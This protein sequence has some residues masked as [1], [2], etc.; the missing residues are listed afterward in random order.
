MRARPETSR[1]RSPHRPAEEPG[2]IGRFTLYGVLQQPSECWQRTIGRK[3]A[4]DI[5]VASVESDHEKPGL[6]RII[7]VVGPKN[8]TN[9]APDGGPRAELEHRIRRANAVDLQGDWYLR[10][11]R[12]GILN[13]LFSPRHWEPTPRSTRYRTIRQ[14]ADGR[15]RIAFATRLPKV[16]Y[17]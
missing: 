9:Q 1:E 13:A 10:R 4:Y 15:S 5:L 3:G 7:L 11:T 6:H 16:E 2:R 17:R 14:S 8:L 12:L